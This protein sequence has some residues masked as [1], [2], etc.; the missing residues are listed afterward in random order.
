MHARETDPYEHLASRSKWTCIV[1]RVRFG[2]RSKTREIAL[3]AASYGNSDGTRNFAGI[4][5]LAAVGECS[6][7]TVSDALDTLRALG[8]LTLVASGSASGRPAKGKKPRYAHSHDSA[9]S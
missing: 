4:K 1:R 2:P 5:R 9:R 8:L 6:E 7:R 3:L